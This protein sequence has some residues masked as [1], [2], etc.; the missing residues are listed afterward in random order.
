METFITPVKAN[1]DSLAEDEL[2]SATNICE[3]CAYEHMVTEACCS[4]L[5]IGIHQPEWQKYY[6]LQDKVKGLVSE[7]AES[8]RSLAEEIGE[9]NAYVTD[10]CNE[11]YR[12]AVLF[13]SELFCGNEF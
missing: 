10:N 8:Y 9:R 4:E 3:G 7:I 2:E 6:V 11:G 13:A 12:K 1:E 5:C